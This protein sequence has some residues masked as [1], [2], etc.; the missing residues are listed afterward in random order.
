M[1][2]SQ[3]TSRLASGISKLVPSFR[4]RM[5]ILHYSCSHFGLKLSK[6]EDSA[7]KGNNTRIWSA[8]HSDSSA[9]WQLASLPCILGFLCKREGPGR[10]GG[11]HLV[12]REATPWAS[13]RLPDRQVKS[14][15]PSHLRVQGASL[16]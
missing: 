2:V 10:L 5:N 6:S 9:A 15:V 4:R 1:L 3:L 14:L 7:R 16:V 13:G 11:L 12:S 8:A